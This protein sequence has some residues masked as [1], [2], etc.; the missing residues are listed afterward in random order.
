MTIR[1]SPTAFALAATILVP[2]AAL[3][4]S[5]AFT[6]KGIG[7][8]GGTSPA[9]TVR[10]VPKGTASLRF[11]MRDLDAPSFRHGGST[12]AYDGKGRVAQGAI[13]YVGP[14]PP[15]GQTH[16]YVWTIEALDAAGSVLGQPEAQGSFPPR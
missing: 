16:R 13:S 12:V 15:T 4:L 10:A 14:C 6:W 9:F 3:A 8:C 11:A 2:S 1:Q 5:A 7:A